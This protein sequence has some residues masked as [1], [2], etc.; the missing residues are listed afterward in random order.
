MLMNHAPILIAF[1]HAGLTYYSGFFP[2][3]DRI[4]Q[5]DPAVVVVAADPLWPAFA[6]ARIPAG[7]VVRLQGGVGGFA[8][9]VYRTR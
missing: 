4:E 8:T 2:F 5:S 1:T 3:R 7:T 9:Q 6:L